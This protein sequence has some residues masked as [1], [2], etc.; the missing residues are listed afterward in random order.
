LN[1]HS[2]QVTGLEA[3]TMFPSRDEQVYR[4]L[5]EAI[6]STKLAP[7]TPLV[8]SAIARQLGVSKTPVRA[9]LQR[10]EGDL[11]V[12]RGDSRRYCVAGFSAERVRNVY[13]VRSRLEGLVAFLATPQMTSDDFEAAS[14]FLDAAAE[15][16]DRD[17]IQLCANLGR[18][19]H[20]LLLIKIDNGFLSDFLRRLSAHVERGRR[21]AA[22]SPVASRHS[23]EQHRQILEAMMVGD[24]ELAEQRMRDH[25]MSFIEE[26][27]ESELPA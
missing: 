27:R 9:A 15:A 4:A 11:L 2:E 19:F 17:D 8:E 26:I 6:L 13:L 14:S 10:L 22:L 7:G 1:T 25:I 16:L 24:R 21:L 20:H 3:L 12:E 18:Q 23:L 5:L